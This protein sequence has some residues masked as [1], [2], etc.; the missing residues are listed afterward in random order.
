MGEP[1]IARLQDMLTALQAQRDA[2][3]NAVV[4]TQAETAALR[5]TLA[6]RDA[7]I[8]ELEARRGSELT[9]DDLRPAAFPSDAI[10][11]AGDRRRT[12]RGPE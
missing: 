7:R 3:L 2:A 4:V 5:R 12:G 9:E 8:A 10:V 1:D 6:A 11:T